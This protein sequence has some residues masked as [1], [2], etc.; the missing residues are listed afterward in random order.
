MRKI[1]NPFFY[2]LSGNYGRWLR[3]AIG[4]VLVVAGWYNANNDFGIF[5]L[6]AGL[7]LTAAG[8]LIFRFSLPHFTSRSSDIQSATTIR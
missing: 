5:S 2:W 1:H 4:A 8:L 3:V 6:V 7:G